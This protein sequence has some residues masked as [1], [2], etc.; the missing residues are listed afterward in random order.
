M[1]RRISGI[2]WHICEIISHLG[3]KPVSGGI[4]L[5]DSNIIG[6]I[7]W[8]MGIELLILLNWLLVCWFVMFKTINSGMTI[9]EYKI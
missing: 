3:I 9:D 4:P 1:I 7:S 8:I 5:N 2:S 6:I